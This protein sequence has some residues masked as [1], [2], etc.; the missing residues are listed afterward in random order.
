M[1]ASNA[2]EDPDASMLDDHSSSSEADMTTR[3]APTTLPVTPGRR[4]S[5]NNSS[6]MATASASML[7]TTTS[8]TNAMGEPTPPGS[9]TRVPSLNAN[10]KR[11]LA[12]PLTADLAD[13]VEGLEP[14]LLQEE[15]EGD[16]KT[17]GATWRGKKHQDEMRKAMEQVIDREYMVKSK[18]FCEYLI[19]K[20]N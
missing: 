8:T 2:S 14:Q 7:P 17:P 3:P 19:G 10:G 9:E 5:S 12:P 18:V 4:H 13:V 1:P 6:S 15:Q 16:S 20:T 11:A